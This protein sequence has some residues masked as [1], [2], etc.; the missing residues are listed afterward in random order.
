[1]ER[2]II[3]T[4]HNIPRGHSSS[5]TA[6]PKNLTSRQEMFTLKENPTRHEYKKKVE[7]KNGFK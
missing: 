2:E 5:N 4:V 1:M 7:V 3:Y 6:R